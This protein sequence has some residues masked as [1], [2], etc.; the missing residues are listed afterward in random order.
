MT[1]IGISKRNIIRVKY[2]DICVY[3]E[4]EIK[5]I[6]EFAGVRLG[7]ADVRLKREMF[8][9]IGGSSTVGSHKDRDHE[10]ALDEAWRAELSD[11]D[12]R[13]FDR[14]TGSINRRYRYTSA[15]LTFGRT[16][17]EEDR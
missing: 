10:I 8:H 1:Q 14:I 16:E 12:K 7:Q 13:L 15:G 6:C 4:K 9:F 3:P 11:G 17:R 5:R 2:E